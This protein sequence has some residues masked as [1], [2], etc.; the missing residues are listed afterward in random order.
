MIHYENNFFVQVLGRSVVLFALID[1]ESRL[2]TK[3]VVFYLFVAWSLVEVIRYPYCIT[4]LNNFN[5]AFLTWLRYTIWIPLYPWGFF[6]E[7][8]LYLRS[9]PYFEETKKFSV[10]LPN[11]WNVTFDMPTALRL[12]LLFAFI[13]G[14]PCVIK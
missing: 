10:P 12:I 3:P 8:V 11:T 13:P 4:Q 7:G 9:I 14:K 6:C 2:Q 5:I 1:S